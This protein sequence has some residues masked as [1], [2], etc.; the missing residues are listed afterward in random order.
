[1][2]P[3]LFIMVRHAGLICARCDDMCVRWYRDDMCVR[4]YRDDMC[5]RW[6]RDGMCVRCHYDALARNIVLFLFACVSRDM[7]G[8]AAIENSHIVHRDAER[9]VG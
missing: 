8:I 9:I 4:W 3:R 6:Y 7:C 2:L 1:M 5:V